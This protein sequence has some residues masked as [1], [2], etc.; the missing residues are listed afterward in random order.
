MGLAD[1]LPECKDALP[2]RT[3]A[4]GERHRIRPL[5]WIVS[6]ALVPVL[7]YDVWQT[8]QDVKHRHAAGAYAIASNLYSPARVQPHQGSD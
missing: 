5:T 3:P 7:L 4:R 8:V 1:G 2:E 6:V